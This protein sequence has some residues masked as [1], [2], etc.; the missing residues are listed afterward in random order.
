MR[1]AVGMIGVQS[2]LVKHLLHDGVALGLVLEAVDQQALGDDVADG[3]AR[4]Q[5]G[6]RILEDDLH[7]PAQRLEFA[8]NAD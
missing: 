3:H 1:V 2:H 7:L 8:A 6:V 4:I 5:G